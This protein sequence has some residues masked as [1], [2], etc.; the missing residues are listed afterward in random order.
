MMLLSKLLWIVLLPG[1][2]IYLMLSLYLAI[3]NFTWLRVQLEF[4]KIFN[5]VTFMIVI[6]KPCQ[7]HQTGRCMDMIGLSIQTLNTHSHLILHVFLQRIPQG[8]TGH[9]FIF[10]MNGMA[11]GYY[12]TLKLLILPT[13]Y[14]LMGYLL[15]TVR[16][17]DYPL[18]L[19]SLNIVIHVVLKRIMF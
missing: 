3:G 5:I 9:I 11:E 17:A 7:F 13:M 1:L 12:Y 16:T 19:K 8:A 15:A 2:K 4:L 14:G 6:G 10:L 18:S